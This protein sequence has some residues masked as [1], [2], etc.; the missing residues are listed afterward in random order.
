M[1]QKILFQVGNLLINISPPD[2]RY[3]GYI[4]KINTQWAYKFITVFWFFGEKEI[5]SSYHEADLHRYIKQQS[6]ELYE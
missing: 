2:E 4:T 5:Q 6:F 1:Q 3:F